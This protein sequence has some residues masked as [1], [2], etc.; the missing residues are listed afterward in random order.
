MGNMAAVKA[1]L[2]DLISSADQTITVLQDWNFNI[3]EATFPLVTIRMGASPIKDIHYGRH[4][5]SGKLG[6]YT[7][8][9]FT[10]HVF[11]QHA[12]GQ[13]Q[14]KTAHELADKIFKYLIT[15]N[16]D[17]GSG[18]VDI[19]NLSMRE[20]EPARASQ[21]ISRVIIDGFILAERDLS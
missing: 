15:H 6:R 5:P 16:K 7:L 19:F 4:L 18:I 11:A 14:S 13:I 17:V 20:S 1:K 2:A 8:Y 10:A 12:E 21:R 9:Y 3:Y